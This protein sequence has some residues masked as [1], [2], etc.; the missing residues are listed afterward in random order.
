[1]FKTTRGSQIQFSL[2]YYELCGIFFVPPIKSQLLKN[3]DEID[4]DNQFILSSG[5]KQKP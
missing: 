2:F 5:G 4:L 1:M 3:Y